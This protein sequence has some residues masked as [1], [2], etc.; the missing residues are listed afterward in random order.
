MRRYVLLITA[1]VVAAVFAMTYVNAVQT[2]GDT[3]RD[4]RQ[5]APVYQPAEPPRVEIVKV[6]LITGDVVYVEKSAGG[7]RVAS[8][9]PA[10]PKKLDQAFHIVKT[11]E[12]IYVIPEG[13]DLAK[14]DI[15]LFDVAHLAR[16]NYTN[17]KTYG[18][19]VKTPPSHG[20]E[21]LTSRIEEL[22]DTDITATAIHDQLRMAALRFPNKKETIRKV[23]TEILTKYVERVWLDKKV[24]TNL[25]Q[26]VPLIGAPKAWQLGYT[27]AGIKIAILDTGID[28][29]HPDFKFPNGTSKIVAAASFVPN[30]NYYDGDGHGTHVASIAAGTGQASGGQYKGVAPDAKLLVGKV[31]SNSGTGQTSWI[32]QGIQWA[33]QNG[34]H[35]ICMSLGGYT[36]SPYDPLAEAA[37]WAVNNGVVV[38]VAAGNYGPQYFT[39]RTP[40]IAYN[41]I[42]VGATDKQDVL[43]EFSS[44]GPTVDWRAKPE[45]VAPGV[46][47]VAAVPGGGYAAYSGTSM[48]TPHV[49]G[50]AAILRQRFPQMSPIDVKNLLLSTANILPGY[51]VYQQ[52]AGRLNVS[53]A[54]TP[55]VFLRPAALN[56]RQS[57]TVT[58]RDIILVNMWNKQ[59][60][61]KFSVATYPQ[62]PPKSFYIMNNTAT[63][64]AGG[65]ARVVFVSNQT[66]PNIYRGVIYVLNASDNKPLAHGIFSAVQLYKLTVKKI[67]ADGQPAAGN[68]IYVISNSTPAGPLIN[69]TDSNGI[70]TFHLPPGVYYLATQRFSSGRAYHIVQVVQ[71]AGNTTVVL[72]ERQTYEVK[73]TQNLAPTHKRVSTYVITPNYKTSFSTFVWYPSSMSD[74]ISTPQPASVSYLL[75][76]VDKTNPSQPEVVESDVLYMPVA[77]F[78]SVTTPKTLNPTYPMAIDTEFRTYA[79]PKVG[80]FVLIRQFGQFT[81]KSDYYHLYHSFGF[82]LNMPK[83]VRTYVN[84]YWVNNP[85]QYAD[86]LIRTEKASDLPNIATPWWSYRAVAPLKELY[87]KG[88]RNVKLYLTAQPEIREDEPYVYLYAGRLR[89]IEY[90]SRQRGALRGGGATYNTGSYTTYLD[91]KVKINNTGIPI[92]INGYAYHSYFSFYNY[93]IDFPLPASVEVW[94]NYTRDHTLSTSVSV[95]QK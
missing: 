84:S 81:Y 76:P 56:I 52:G 3:A 16:E 13:I 70:A 14:F 40:G 47:I 85:I 61:V 77:F 12:N 24:R 46:S 50:A 34:A 87:D 17:D 33:V 54:V 1:L 63:I 43:A 29:N 92:G 58:Y 72:D 91:A 59:I 65:T 49:A 8:I 95:R 19:I 62:A 10:D 38:V 79:T 9:E 42:T 45:I 31:L 55:A 32:I 90:H 66:N 83:I 7:L 6:V 5:A 18:V 71:L 15:S 20:I 74:F 53:Y 64:P 48:A 57:T 73:L 25:H 2:G 36:T 51:D 86:L 11:G 67:A 88:V 28:P 4:L 21:T 60:T 27:G 44:R 35:V 26:S 93:S 30:E 82:K 94:Y 68:I 37:D 39:I 89:G 78:P 41:V 23:Y 22:R 80:S 75:L 69:Y